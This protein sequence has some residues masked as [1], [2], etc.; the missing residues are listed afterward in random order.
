MPKGKTDETSAYTLILPK[1]EWHEVKV[2][3]TIRGKTLR[4]F[5]R[6]A[7]RKEVEAA[8][9]SGELPRGLKAP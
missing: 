4:D 6:E 8:K 1:D 5:F 3:A 9:K 7:M 2:L